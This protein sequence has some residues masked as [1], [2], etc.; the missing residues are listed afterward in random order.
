MNDAW[1][2]RDVPAADLFYLMGVRWPYAGAVDCPVCGAGGGMRIADDPLGGYWCACRACDTAGDPLRVYCNY[3]GVLTLKTATAS[4]W[5]LGVVFPDKFFDDPFQAA[6]AASEEARRRFMAACTPPAAGA[7]AGDGYARVTPG[8]LSDDPPRWWAVAAAA[9][10]W[11]AAAEVRNAAS[12]LVVPAGDRLGRRLSAW[13]TT[14]R[15][16]WPHWKQVRWAGSGG[17]AL[18]DGTA[19]GA[20]AWGSARVVATRPELALSAWAAHRKASTGFPPVSLW[21]EP[22]A[23]DPRPVLPGGRY[24][25]WTDRPDDAAAYRLARALPGADLAVRPWADRA[26]ED[27]PKW[28]TDWVVGRAEPWPDVL[29]RRL[30][31]IGWEDQADLLGRIGWDAGW[32]ADSGWPAAAVRAA[33]LAAAREPRPESTGVKVGKKWV[34][35]RPGNAALVFAD[36]TLVSTAAV[37]I[38]VVRED[39]TYD[40][41]VIFNNGRYPFSR[42]RRLR[43]RVLDVIDRTLAAAGVGPARYHP[44]ARRYVYE[45]AV[46][47]SSPSYK[48]E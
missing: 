6:Y 12:T 7:G 28:L 33:D 31:Q 38:R 36:G 30:E 40:G 48:R 25:V 37:V 43:V 18:P 34:L 26:A 45:H 2:G 13:V 23:G 11:A 16:G 24:V 10:P 19:A 47:C 9:T 32:G 41:D 39:D 21:I 17:V 42:E 44:A 15:R 27:H 14:Y 8:G 1:P 29:A 22:T 20:D 46:A 5:R 35:M 3:V 4:A